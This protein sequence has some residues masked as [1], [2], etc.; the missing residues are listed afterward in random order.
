MCKFTVCLKIKD[1]KIKKDKKKIQF[2]YKDFL[3]ELSNYDNKL[4][5]CSSSSKYQIICYLFIS[6]LLVPDLKSSLKSK[7]KKDDT[8]RI[9]QET[10]QLQIFS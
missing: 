10:N 9:S 4:Y 2:E 7:I 5:F 1:T 6:I 3:S 8:L